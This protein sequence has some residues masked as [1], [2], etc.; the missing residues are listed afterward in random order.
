MKAEEMRGERLTRLGA[1]L[2]ALLVVGCASNPER[3]A[4]PR[5][6]LEPYNRAVYRFNTDFDRAFMQPVAKA[7]QAVT[8]EP[9]D[10]GVT[11]FFNNLADLT[12]AV[13][14]VLQFKMSRAG[15]DVGRIFI[16]S[17]VGVLGFVDVA[18]NVGLPSYKED[19]GQTLGY[20]GVEPGAYFVLPFLGPSSIR[21]TIGLAGDIYTDPLVN[22]REDKVRWGLVG[23]RVVDRRADLLTAGQILEDA[24][25]DPYSFLRDVY[26]QRRLSLVY[27]GNPP[28][29]DGEN[30]FWNDVDFDAKEKPSTP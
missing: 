7:Y 29:D 25:I 20:W 14:N 3:V 24:A 22:V 8:P 5:D 11:N 18:T 12:S 16:N 10:R 13:N 21:D 15:S 26:L 30:D 17:T 1:L 2:T 4:D 23:L 9:V 6:P 28:T 19:F 27:D